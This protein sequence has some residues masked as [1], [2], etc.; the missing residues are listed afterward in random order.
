[1][2]VISMNSTSPLFYI[3]I[4][5]VLV[6]LGAVLPFLMIMQ[7]LES[8]LLLNFFSYFASVA[9]L[10]LGFIGATMYVRE[11]RGKG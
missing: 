7:I 9:G 11:K 1:M 4:G 10:F 6:I 8:T 2:L 5:F 3:L